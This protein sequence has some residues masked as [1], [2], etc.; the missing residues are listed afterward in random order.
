M[1]P[2]ATG[3][4]RHNPASRIP[5][6]RN[7]RLVHVSSEASQGRFKD[8]PLGSGV[9]SELTQSQM[10]PVRALLIYITSVF[11]LGALIAPWVYWLV[12][13]LADQFPSLRGLADS[14]FHR[15]VNRSLLIVAVIG[16][17]P[18]LRSLGVNSIA[19]IGLAKPDPADRRRLARGFLLGLLTMLA[20][21]VVAMLAGSRKWTPDLTQQPF[22]EAG[23]ILLSASSVSLLEELLFRG[24]LFGSLRRQHDWRLALVISSAVYAVLH[25]FQRVKSPAWITWTSGLEQLGEMMGG[26]VHLGMLVPGFLSLTL[27][28][29]ALG[30]AYQRTG[31]LYFSIG[32]HAG[33]IFWLKTLN[34]WTDPGPAGKGLL[35]VSKNLYD[36]W[37]GF[38]VSVAAF[39]AVCFLTERRPKSPDAS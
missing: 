35:K 19:T 23:G 20:V 28:G 13:S 2:R 26:F 37:L 6:Q 9:Q 10:H 33:W 30:L 27:A 24:T 36:G 4:D 22:L 11:V 39:V 29:M 14:P 3:R 31:N 32:L 17:W 16:L 12:Q 34:L 15:Y 5:S 8:Y 7:L 38:G 18:F 25:F 1:D 21:A